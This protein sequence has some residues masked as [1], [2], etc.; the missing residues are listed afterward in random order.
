MHRLLVNN[1]IHFNGKKL[2]DLHIL[3]YLQH[4][5]DC[6]QC[7]YQWNVKSKN[8]TKTEKTLLYIAPWIIFYLLGSF[9]GLQFNIIKWQEESRMGYVMLSLLTDCGIL[10]F[11]YIS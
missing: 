1:S 3:Q 6:V 5:Q 4:L 7:L 8:M 9:I 2:E 10:M 11:K